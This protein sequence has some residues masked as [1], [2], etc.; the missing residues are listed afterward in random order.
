MYRA[1]TNVPGCSGST[2][3][4]AL[5][6]NR[7]SRETRPCAASADANARAPGLEPAVRSATTTSTDD[8]FMDVH[9]PICTVRRSKCSYMA[10]E[11]TSGPYRLVLGQRDLE[12]C[13]RVVTV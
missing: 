10:P 1:A 5:R 6:P 4:I 2:V 8:F 12:H 3:A 13:E 9:L 11:A 7:S